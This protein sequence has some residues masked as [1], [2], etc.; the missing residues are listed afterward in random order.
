MEKIQAWWTENRPAARLLFLDELGRVERLLRENPELGIVYTAHKSGTIRRI[1]L[2]QSEYHLY[3][4]YVPSRSEIF[5][6][7]IWGAARGRGPRL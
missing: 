7:T 4:R 5:V 6:V 3:Y 1:L 2:I